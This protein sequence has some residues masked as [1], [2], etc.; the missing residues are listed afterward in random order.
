M[1]VIWTLLSVYDSIAS[2]AT[3]DAQSKNG[4]HLGG[5]A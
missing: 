5:L 1:N 2:V 4:L 3:S